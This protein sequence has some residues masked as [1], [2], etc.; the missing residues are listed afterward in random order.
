MTRE[1]QRFAALFVTLGSALGAYALQPDNLTVWGNPKLAAFVLGAFMVAFTVLNN[2]LSSM[3][4]EANPGEQQRQRIH[5]LEQMLHEK[6][7]DQNV[8]VNVPGPKPDY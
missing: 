1:T 4:S 2:F 7:T 6:P 8:T 5:D 3:F